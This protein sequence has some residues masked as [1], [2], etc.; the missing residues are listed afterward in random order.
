M[1]VENSAIAART[2]THSFDE[3]YGAHFEYVHRI[4]ARLS[5]RRDVEDL[6]QEVFVVV[7]RKLPAFEGRA[8]ITSWLFAI[9][10]RVVGAQARKERVRRVFLDVFKNDDTERPPPIDPFE[11]L[12]HGERRERVSKVL[13]R[14]AWKKKVVLLMFEV[15]G[16]S[17]AD[18]AQALEIPVATVYTRLHHARRDFAFLLSGF[19]G[20]EP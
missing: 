16:W 4:V 17:C 1:P 11:A 15:E 2:T 5:G 12:E 9:C 10:H 8:S 18:I 13:S 20:G 6:V 7:H 3:V 14:L 19:E